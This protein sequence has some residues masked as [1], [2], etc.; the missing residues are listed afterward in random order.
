MAG[1]GRNVF[2][3]LFLNKLPISGDIDIKGFNLLDV[4]YI[5]MTGI[6]VP[7]N[8]VAGT[9]RMFTNTAT[10]ELSVRTNAG[11]TV[12]LEGAGGGDNNIDGGRADS[13]YLPVQAF[14]GGGA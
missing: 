13:V 4:E 11:A 6:S 8:P 1:W 12:S 3:Q 5:D 7:S 14:D 2:R 9:R 10:G